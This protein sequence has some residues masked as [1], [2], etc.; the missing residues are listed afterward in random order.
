[1]T[2]REDKRLVIGIGTGRSGSVS[3]Y[4]L[5]AQQEGVAFSHE[6]RPLLPWQ[7]SERAFARSLR[8]LL[9]REGRVVGDVCHS[10]LPYIP[11]LMERYPEARVVCLERDCKLVVDSFINKIQGKNK[12]H[13]IAD[14]GKRWTRDRRFDP[15]FPK[16]AETELAPAIEKY[17]HEYHD[18]VEALIARYPGR[19]RKWQTAD[20]LNSGETMAE[21]LDY[22]GIP[23]ERQNLSVGS[24]HNERRDRSARPGRLK[25]LLNSLRALFR[26]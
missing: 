18:T 6:H 17:W 15:T 4:H 10:W 14:P 2:T 9:G 3:F 24:R 21:L 7:V 19:I 16:Y 11:L 5:M 12:N 1:M 20:A 26:A 23:R 22:V 8:S 13:W 25:R